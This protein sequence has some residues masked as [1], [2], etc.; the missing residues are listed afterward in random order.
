MSSVNSPYLAAKTPKAAMRR[1]RP[2][3]WQMAGKRLLDVLVAAGVLTILCPFFP[4]I[5]LAIKLTSRGPVLYVWPVVGQWGRPLK[6]YKFRTMVSGADAMK[7]ELLGHN[8]STGPVFKMRK[9]PRVTPMGRILRK[10]SLDELPQLWN[11][12]KGDLSLVGPRPVLADE[13]ARFD[14]WHRR[15]LEVKPGMICLW[16]IHGQPRDFDEWVRMDI[17]YV[18]NWSLWLDIRVL[19]RGAIYLAAGKNY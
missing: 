8:E 12:L 11:V 3:R 5:A 7:S 9:D 14:E 4:V 13:W 2:V 17:E 18:D 10:F 16:H 6:A 19:A 1:S 15:K